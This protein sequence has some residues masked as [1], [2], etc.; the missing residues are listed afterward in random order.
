MEEQQVSQ[1]I[2][3]QQQNLYSG[4]ITPEILEAMKAEARM[5]AIQNTSTN[6]DINSPSNKIMYVDRY[7]RR[8]LTVAELI[9]VFLIAC[10]GVLG[11]QGVWFLV[12]NMPSIE[13]KWNK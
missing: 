2:P 3:T 4:P 9:F 10:G 11:L 12:N 1:S 5:R 8:N 13:I 6:Q 7:I